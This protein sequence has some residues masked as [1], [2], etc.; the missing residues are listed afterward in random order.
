M[1]LT[2]PETRSLA[3]AE[4]SAMVSRVTNRVSVGNFRHRSSGHGLPSHRLDDQGLEAYAQLSLRAL[5]QTFRVPSKTCSADVHSSTSW[6]CFFERLGLGLNHKQPCLRAST[7][8]CIGNGMVRSLTML[9]E[10]AR[11]R[12]EKCTSG[13]SSHRRS[14]G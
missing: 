14:E 7:W 6:T 13:H 1:P 9:K 10:S 2:M 3:M 11:G 12:H 4:P 8:S 5:S